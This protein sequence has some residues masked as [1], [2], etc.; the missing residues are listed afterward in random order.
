MDCF[1]RD[2][3]LRS[4]V[5]DQERKLERKM[6]EKPAS[7][8]IIAPL[9]VKGSNFFV[10]EDDFVLP[11]IFNGLDQGNR[12]AVVKETSLGANGWAK[13]PPSMCLNSDHA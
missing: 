2:S 1:S 10:V 8:K 11:K 13:W 12:L 9:G 3:L 5:F 6:T 4:L 7:L